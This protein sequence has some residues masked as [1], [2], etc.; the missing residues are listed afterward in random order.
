MEEVIFEITLP[1]W[2]SFAITTMGS[3]AAWA[4]GSGRYKEIMGQGQGPLG[5]SLFSFLFCFLESH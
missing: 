5:Y 2:I 4:A 3:K 1:N